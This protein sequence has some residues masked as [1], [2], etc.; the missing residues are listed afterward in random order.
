MSGGWIT[1]QD[2]GTLYLTIKQKTAFQ[3]DFMSHG[4]K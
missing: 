2:I 4:E 1:A 3:I